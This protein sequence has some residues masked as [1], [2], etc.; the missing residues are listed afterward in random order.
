MEEGTFAEDV[1]IVEQTDDLKNLLIDSV[2]NVITVINTRLKNRQSSI[3]MPNRMLLSGDVM[4]ALLS[5]N[6]KYTRIARAFLKDSKLKKL[7]PE[8]TQE[9][10][11]TDLMTKNI[12]T[13]IITNAGSG[14]TEQLF[15]LIS[16]LI[17]L[18][19]DIA[20]VSDPSGSGESIVKAIPAAIKRLQDFADGKIIELPIIIGLS[21][22]EVDGEID[23]VF[24]KN[25]KIRNLTE[26]EKNLLLDPRDYNVKSAIFTTLKQKMIFTGSWEKIEKIFSEGKSKISKEFVELD[27]KISSIRLAL[28]LAMSTTDDYFIANEAGSYSS[29][30]LSSQMQMRPFVSRR[31]FANTP[32]KL[33]Q[34]S[35]EVVINK[36]DTIKS[37]DTSTIEIAKRR[38]LSA[39]GGRDDPTD[40]YIDAVMC[41]ENI[42]GAETE[43]A[44]KVCASIA[45]L[46]TENVV[47]QLAVYEKLKGV[48]DQRSKLVHGSSKVKNDKIYEYSKYS[49][50]TGVKLMNT[51][52]ESNQ[53]IL[54]IKPE[55]R[56]K[57]ILLS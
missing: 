26:I 37:I 15:G 41:W 21:G 22:F 39:A 46:V 27:E 34:S 9:A 30:V 5:D 24:D 25:T 42:I 40:A 4:Q 6:S 33:K 19:I 10:D 35:S 23:I 31:I 50:L 36:Y 13:N 28:V 51:I 38:L 12:S 3:D 20:A 55:D 2:P 16:S 14:G 17:I 56:S 45:K 49:I 32:I 29:G 54:N 44:F 18:A 47:D 57:I 1:C 52:L 48:Y 43:V 11:L 8:I 53:E 7:F